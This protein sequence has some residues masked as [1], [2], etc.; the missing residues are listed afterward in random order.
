[1]GGQYIANT[2]GLVDLGSDNII[3][4]NGIVY[5]DS[6]F[7]ATDNTA[8]SKG[9]YYKNNTNF[10]HVGTFLHK[11]E[12]FNGSDTSDVSIIKNAGS[13]KSLNLQNGTG[14]SVFNVDKD[15]NMIGNTFGT[16]YKG[17]VPV[18]PGGTG[19][20]LR[21]DGTFAASLTAGNGTEIAAG[22]IQANS[23]SN[24]QIG[25]SYTYLT[26]DRAKTVSHSN[27][28]AIAGTLPAPGASFPDGWFMYV[29][30][31]GAGA[32]T[33]TSTTSTINGSATLVLTTGQGARIASNGTNYTAILGKSSGSA[34]PLTTKGDLYTF[35]TVDARLP[36]G[37]NGQVLTV[38]NTTATGNKWAD[39]T[40]TPRA[41]TPTG[42]IDGTNVTFTLANTPANTASVIIVLGGLTQFNGIDYTVSGSTVTFTT[43]P[44]VGSTIFAY[45]NS[46]TGSATGLVVS[47]INQGTS[48]TAGAVTNTWYKYNL[49]AGAVAL[50]LP[51]AV[52][53]TNPY[54]VKNKHT[55]NNTVI[56]TGGQNA[57]GTT[58]ITIT[59]NQSLTFFSDG[60]NWTID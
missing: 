48:T 36:I 16:V 45:F 1:M 28:A 19:T 29:V 37:T 58:T 50:T 32:L 38:D 3:K 56:F 57:D 39:A 14:T 53:N 18:S 30:N 11:L 60:T 21:A 49:T 25:V 44:I 5:T 8:S 47:I 13:G 55:A 17:L 35:S 59:P 52:G 4:V 27:A 24:T 41:E 43:A 12:M 9:T 23:L 22:V 15:G 26:T 54:T 33:I 10:A 34:S 46:N 31:T 7:T 40:Y 2:V 42:A 20:F 51:T 6:M